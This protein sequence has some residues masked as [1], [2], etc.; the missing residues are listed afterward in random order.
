MGINHDVLG[1]VYPPSP[2]YE[3]GREKIREFATA[4]GDSNPA[5]HDI[6][7]AQALGHR[8]IVAPPTFAFTVTLE[9][10]RAVM[11]DP[12][13]NIDFAR[14]V[15][16]EQRFVYARPIVAGDTLVVVASL[17]SLRTVAGNDMVSTRFDIATPEGEPVA[18][19]WSMT[20]A[21]AAAEEAS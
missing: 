4:I 3:V 10:F 16:G 11:Q 6:V 20:V 13:L 17:D 9:A 12:E 7:H 18:S 15:H 14:V 5:Y 1:K 19:T 21:R 8:D 2:V